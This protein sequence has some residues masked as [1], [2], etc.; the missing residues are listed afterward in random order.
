MLKALSGLP[1][2]Q[3]EGLVASRL[4]L[5]GLDVP[6]PDVNTLCRCQKGSTVQVS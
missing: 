2:R 1:L 3:T 6:M 4:K 5:A